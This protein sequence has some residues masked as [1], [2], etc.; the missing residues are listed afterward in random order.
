MS[1]SVVKFYFSLDLQFIFPLD[2]IYEY[3]N[4]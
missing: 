1:D 4:A 3:F 2:A